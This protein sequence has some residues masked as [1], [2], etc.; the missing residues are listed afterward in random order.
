[1]INNMFQLH[2]FFNSDSTCTFY[3]LVKASMGTKVFLS[4]AFFNWIYNIS[5]YLFTFIGKSNPYFY[6]VSL[7]QYLFSTEKTMSSCCPWSH[8][9]SQKSVKLVWQCH[10]LLSGF[11]AKDHL[12]WVLCGS[13]MI[14]VIMKFSGGLCTDLL[15]FALQLRKSLG[16]LR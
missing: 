6:S 4:C 3:Q 10:Q 2:Y 15:A 11:L 7:F 16:H 5:A 12:P 13:L 9:C 8:G 1:M 14:R